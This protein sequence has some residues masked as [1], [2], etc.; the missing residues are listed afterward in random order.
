M[1]SSRGQRS[2]DDAAASI[3]TRSQ[4]KAYSS[5]HKPTS[6]SVDNLFREMREIEGQMKNLDI[7]IN[8]SSSHTLQSSPQYTVPPPTTTPNQHMTG[9]SPGIS[10]SKP[11]GSMSY[12]RSPSSRPSTPRRGNSPVVHP[13]AWGANAPRSALPASASKASTR[14]A[15]PTRSATPTRYHPT[16]T[17]RQ[18]VPA[19]R[20]TSTTKSATTTAPRGRAGTPRANASG[21]TSSAASS[22]TRRPVEDITMDRGVESSPESAS[23]QQ[24]GLLQQRV[25]ELESDVSRVKV[26][27]DALAEEFHTYKARTDHRMSQMMSQL[28]AAL[29]WIRQ[30]DEY[31]AAFGGAAPSSNSNNN[32]CANQ[33]V[34]GAAGS[35]GI[36]ASSLSPVR[37]LD[38]SEAGN[39][40]TNNNN[41]NNNNSNSGSSYYATAGVGVRS[42][43]PPSGPITMHPTTSAALDHN[44]NN[45]DL[46]FASTLHPNDNSGDDDM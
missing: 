17:A 1:Y 14:P 42:A 9:V 19:T 30:V 26:R 4:Q 33:S 28:E 3:L 46:S 11:S 40:A 34:A 45:G 24:H 31:A 38:L 8:G 20:S 10:T 23:E 12:G 6:D 22:G 25:A 15:T 32:S 27:Q 21:P 13:K 43:V 44:H 2:V 29:Q 41:N 39:G 16:T 7:H 36:D 35:D 18:T 5:S 37:R